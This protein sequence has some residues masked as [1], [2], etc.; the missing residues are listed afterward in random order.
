MTVCARFPLCV[1][2]LSA[3][4]ELVPQSRKPGP[5]VYDQITEAII[6]SVDE[7]IVN[8]N[9]LL[10][11]IVM[12]LCRTWSSSSARHRARRSILLFLLTRYPQ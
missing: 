4:T 9:M 3:L 8:S 2:K 10:C 5:K 7:T 6:V 12:T 1:G 11:K